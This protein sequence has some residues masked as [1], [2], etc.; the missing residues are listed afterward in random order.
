MNTRAPWV[1]AVVLC[2]VVTASV[3]FLWP[4][5]T[6]LE[7][8]APVAAKS[9]NKTT[10]VAEPPLP[11]VA[12]AKAWNLHYQLAVD[13]PN[14]AGGR[15]PAKLT[16]RAILLLAPVQGL[17]DTAW[18]A[19][20]LTD[21]ALEPH[22]SEDE[23][24]TLYG[25]DTAAM[26]LNQ[27]DKA[28]LALPFAVLRRTDGTVQEV[29]FPVGVRASVKGLLTTLV[30]A[31]QF[32]AP[33]DAKLQRWE[34]REAT[35]NGSYLATYVLLPDGKVNKAWQTSARDETT[36]ATHVPGYECTF[37][38]QFSVLAGATT[39][40]DL[41]WKGLLGS[42]GEEKADRV[43]FEHQLTLRATAAQSA[44]WA[45]LDL[46]ELRRFEPLLQ[47]QTARTA[48]LKGDLPELLAAVDHVNQRNAT[49][50]LGRLAG[51]I[52]VK[53]RADAG[54]L[55]L[56]EQK[57]RATR[58][59]EEA[60]QQVLIDA[61]VRADTAVSRNAL[62]G[63]MTDT[64][65]PQ[66]LREQVLASTAQVTTPDALFVSDLRKLVLFSEDEVYCSLAAVTTGAVLYR[67]HELDPK[68]AADDIRALIAEAGRLV[69][70][71]SR[72]PRTAQ[73]DPAVIANWLLAAGNTRSALA[74]PVLHEGLGH[75]EVAVRRSAALSLQFQPAASVLPIMQTAMSQETSAEVR[76]TLVQVA[77]MLD[78][79][80]MQDLVTRALMTD[81][82]DMVRLSAAQAIAAWASTAPDWRK[83]LQDAL[84][85][86]KSKKVRARLVA[87][88]TPEPAPMPLH[89]IGMGEL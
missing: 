89:P 43:R 51:A 58:A 79:A 86:E 22:E 21:I 60:L 62:I 18:Q 33:A 8:P 36:A 77:G 56:I 6:N 20:R 82:S 25:G 17:K 88:L 37:S 49:A 40:A 31:S 68:A 69:G 47:A 30:T 3:V 57:L 72:A 13:A 81:K 85:K 12:P 48:G 76:D 34:S 35:A 38:G 27:Y 64:G 54:A 29:R 73:P 44:L 14:K 71:V 59:E 46:H 63:L 19:A 24:E 70:P 78:A 1:I 10:A 9:G 55:G 84:A 53:I 28:D 15:T 83:V 61:I 2:T 50:D 32:S 75:K 39:A 7:Q 66:L 16:L 74:L 52:A 45:K 67:W 80:P 65:L 5:S 26:A 87:L 42:L 11:V 23:S 4:K 41:H